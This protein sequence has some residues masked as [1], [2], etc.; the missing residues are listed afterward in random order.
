MTLVCIGPLNN[1]SALLSSASDSV[2]PL[3]GRELVEKS[4][5]RIA[6]MGGD[7]RRG[8]PEAEYNIK[9]NIAAA[10]LVA[11]RCPVPLIYAGF[12]IGADVLTGKSL[13]TADETCPV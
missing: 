1:I 3:N 11:E 6:V 13:K 12:E 2:S 9:C 7:F 10:Q 5:S 8:V 4:V